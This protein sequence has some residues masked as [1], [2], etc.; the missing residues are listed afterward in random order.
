V[1]P[2]RIRAETLDWIETIVVGLDLCPFAKKSMDAA[3][4]RVQV[5]AAS[6]PDELSE[7]LVAELRHLE[8][9]DGA[10]IDSTLIIHPLL[11]R[12]FLDFNDFLAFAEARLEAEGFEGEFQIASFHP[13]YRFEGVD[14]KAIGNFTNRSPHPMLHIL[15]ESRVSQA[16]A[17]HP[18]P[19]SIPSANIAR[20]ETLGMPALRR[21][22]DS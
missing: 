21:L 12:D 7:T 20:L 16:I 4:L 5:S 17:S 11:F 3:G 9:S 8:S 15:R 6:T 2:K 14:P 10:A 22:L 19:D 1:D 13:D 18:D